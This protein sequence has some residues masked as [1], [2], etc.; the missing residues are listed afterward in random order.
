MAVIIHKKNSANTSKILSAK[1]KKKQNNG[2]LKKHFGKLKRNID[3]ISYQTAI[4]EDE[5]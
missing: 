1:L 3:G 4:R 5:D 2:N